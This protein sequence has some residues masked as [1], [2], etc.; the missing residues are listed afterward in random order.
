MDDDPAYV[1][2]RR[3][4]LNRFF[5][6]GRGKVPINGY[7]KALA[8]ARALPK[9][10]R[11]QGGSSPSSAPSLWTFPVLSPIANNWGGGA[12]ARTDAIAVDPTKEDIVYSGSEGGLAKSSDGGLTW[13]YVSDDLPSQSIRCIVVDPQR[14]NI[15]YA[16]TGTQPFYGV[17]VYRSDDAGESWTPLGPVDFQGKAVGK[18]VVDPATAGSLT[19]TTLYASVSGD[20]ASTIWQS[21]NSGSSWRIIRGP[22]YGA[23][24][25]YDIVIDPNPNP[26]LFITAPDGVFKK[27]AA[28]ENWEMMLNHF[29]GE[30]PAHLALAM[31]EHGQSVLYLAYQEPT[32]VTVI[33][34]GDQGANWDRR[35][36]TGGGMYC[37][38]VDPVHANRIFVGAAGDL[39]YS[40]DDG[41]NWLNSHEVHVDI[42]AIAFCPSNS[43]RNYLGTDGGIYRADSGENDPEILWYDKN[44]NLPGVLMQ[45]ISLSSNGNMVLGSQDNGTQF[46]GQNP[47]PWTMVMGG[48]GFKP[49]IHPDDGEI[50]YFVD[51]SYG[52]PVGPAHPAPA[53]MV[54]GVWTTIT[55][56]EAYGESSSAFPAMDVVFGEV[57]Q[58]DQDIV[59]MG[60]QN[61]WRSLDSGLTWTRI[62]GGPGGITPGI[63]EIVRQAPSDTNVIYILAQGGRVFRTRNANDPEPEWTDITGSDLPGGINNLMVDPTN[64]RTAYLAC[65]SDVY[66]TKD[67][68]GSWSNK[69]GGQAGGFIYTDLA[70]DPGYPNRVIAA[71]YLGVII[72]VNGGLTWENISAGLPPGMPVLSLSLN[73]SSRQLAAGT[74]GRGAY[75]M[76]VPVTAVSVISP[77]GGTL[78]SGTVPVNAIASNDVVGVQ[79][80]LDDDLL[81]VEDTSVPYSVNW[82]TTLVPAGYHTLSAVARDGA[83]VTTTS[84]S[85]TVWIDH[86]APTVSI[87][88]PLDGESVS[89]TVTISATAS[90]D[91]GVVAVQ[92]YIDGNPYG[93][94]LDSPPYSRNWDTTSFEYGTHHLTAEAVD[95]ANHT[96][97]SDVVGVKVKN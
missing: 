97:M 65:T 19:S 59:V 77:L 38:G 69:T 44:E 29:Y 18:I 11:S 64:S 3:E 70:I 63:V 93:H 40:L 9:S 55:P 54:H 50:Y 39:R 16:G 61:V 56:L 90:D 27:E 10:S 26:T 5:G 87:T 24:G 33:S 41:L 45:G 4:F 7:A 53:R 89:G 73:A 88:E 79:F 8:A 62:G 76:N 71:S 78:V 91:V 72:T 92:F 96:T 58:T 47:P 82:D 48:D 35:G 22:T 74:Y 80:K 32:H 13:R 2:A 66:K 84:A 42:H 46:H 12:S 60:Y 17:G 15:V 21:D 81:D 67:M 37:F 20:G 94:Y 25:C 51:L 49:R 57:G 75:L 43:N 83:N 6:T 23:Q 34:T 28:K 36:R 30:G 85:V 95:G 31:D 14:P 1:E 52:S 86:A 68:G